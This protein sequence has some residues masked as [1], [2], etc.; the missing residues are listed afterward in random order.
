MSKK[1][2]NVSFENK[3]ARLEEITESLENNELGL[4]KSITLFEEGVALSKE[5]LTILEKAELKVKILKKDL[6]SKNIS[7]KDSEL[8]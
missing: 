5:C 2:S 7:N 3:L 1:K 6:D 8:E 4:E